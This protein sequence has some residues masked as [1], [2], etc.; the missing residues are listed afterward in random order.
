MFDIESFKVN[1]QENPI[2]IVEAT[3]YFSWKFKQESSDQ[4]AYRIL[5]SS[6]PIVDDS[7][8]DMWDSGLVESDQM[9]GIAYQGNVFQS[10]KKYYARLISFS[11]NN[12]T[13][14]LDSF[15]ETALINE[16]DWLGK[17]VSL[18]ASA[19]GGTLYIRKK[20]EIEPKKVV[21]ARAYVCGLGYYEF[22]INGKKVTKSVLN[23][24]ETNYNKTI[25]YDTLDITP[26][27]TEK[28]VVFGFELGYGW[29]GARVL[30]AQLYIEYT[31]GTFIE[32]HTA[33]G[34]GWWVSRTPVTHNSIYDG[35]T[36]DARIEDAYGEGWCSPKFEPS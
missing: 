28:E 32:E 10:R 21:R 17:W 18:P 4:K 15:F 9:I 24:G 31:D 23:P 30:K 16:E 36:Y 14:T 11:V 22:S 20:I 19:S 1:H 7:K 12:E 6:A 33:A 34:P 27:L 26:F 8:V 13:S 29:Y 25:L 3:P 35:E 2:N 5:V